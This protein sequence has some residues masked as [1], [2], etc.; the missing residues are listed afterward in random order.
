MIHK[1]DIDHILQK[2]LLVLVVITSFVLV[3]GQSVTTR[4]NQIAP[5]T[6]PPEARKILVLHSPQMPERS[7]VAI[8]AI[9]NLQSEQWLRDLEIEVQNNF[10]KPIY[11][12]EMDLEFPQVVI[13]RDDGKSGSLVIPLMFG[14][15][16]LMN[17]GEHAASTDESIQ[18]GEKYVFKIPE[19]YRKGMESHLAKNNIA[20]SAITKIRLRIYELSLGDGTGF[21]MG[22]PFSNKQ[23]LN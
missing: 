17:P 3:N 9:R 13:D 21:E 8:N 1:I 22:E 4:V 20:L 19:S 14:K 23:S 6:T 5:Q 12:L 2:S 15:F 18:P 16:A 10:N 7:T 11:H